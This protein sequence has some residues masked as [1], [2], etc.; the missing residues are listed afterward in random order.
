MR[1]YG[2]RGEVFGLVVSILTRLGGR[3][4]RKAK[5]GMR[6]SSGCFNPHPAWRP[7]A[8][9]IAAPGGTQRRS[10][11]PHP[12]WRPGAT[13]TGIIVDREGQMFQSS[14]GLEAGCDAE[15]DDPLGRKLGVSIL[16][17]LGGRV[18]RWMIWKMRS[19]CNGFQSS[20]G[21][22]AGCD[23]RSHAKCA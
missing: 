11:N 1:L 23:R 14:P 7:G 13:V 19:G 6:P 4:R 2:F 22:E 5:L 18:R 21:L 10:F 15:E 8:T 12:A 20:P 17:R 16:T 3:V 9:R